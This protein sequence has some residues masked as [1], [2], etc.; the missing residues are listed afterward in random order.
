[1]A[2]HYGICETALKRICRDYGIFRWPYRKLIMINKR[3]STLQKDLQQMKKSKLQIS[4]DLF[5]S[6][7]KD[8]AML[9][10]EKDH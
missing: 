3:I 4:K 5:A 10:K 2:E 1:M 6:Y 9:Q 8:I 7:E